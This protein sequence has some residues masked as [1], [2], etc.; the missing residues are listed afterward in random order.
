MMRTPL[1]I[2][3][4]LALLSV[5]QV[6]AAELRLNREELRP[7]SK[8]AYSPLKAKL[9]SLDFYGRDEAVKLRF[10]LTNTS[11]QSLWVLRWQLPSEDMDAN[12][13]AVTRDGEVVAYE[14]RLVKRAQPRA[15]DYVEIKAG[16]TWSVI[17]DP[18]SVYDMRFSGN[19][20]VNLH[21][22][23]YSVR[24]SAPEV[25]NPALANAAMLLPQ[26]QRP[27]MDDQPHTRLDQAATPAV[28]FGFQGVP[29]PSAV[30]PDM[31]DA[32]I[33][34]Y[35]K[36]TTSQQT[37]LTTA[38]NNA[39]TLT[40]KA[41][42]HLTK[43]P[44]GSVLYTTWFGAYNSSR[45][46]TVKDH[47]TKANDAFVNK[48]VVYDCGCKDSAY[49]Y[50][51][52]TQ[53]YKI[54]VCKAFWSAT[55]LGRDSKAGTL[56]HEMTHFNVVGSTQDHIYGETGAKNLA[57]TDPAKAIFNADNHEYFAEDQP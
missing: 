23:K 29:N 15:E 45:F 1:L 26:G 19:Y 27:A 9:E 30:R 32:K 10:S 16:E 8:P 13:F 24:F 20:Q 40:S 52:P 56:V 54:Y 28:Q 12:L 31:I 42:S 34:G 17:F 35:S 6:Q 21:Q 37:A 18:T 57:K 47:Y 48:S 36:C 25:M 2:T 5:G 53:P 22:G 50:V 38:H 7:E 49:A 39:I 3:G 33:S 11:S 43:N 44:S 41:I 4:A 46:A 14:G 55:A 51:Y